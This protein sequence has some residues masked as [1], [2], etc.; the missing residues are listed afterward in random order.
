MARWVVDDAGSNSQ[1]SEDEQRQA[2]VGDPHDPAPLLGPRELPPEVPAARGYQ[3]RVVR[4]PLGGGDRLGLAAHGRRPRRNGCGGRVRSM[5]LSRVGP[6]ADLGTLQT[7]CR[8]RPRRP[9]ASAWANGGG[10]A[11][12]GHTTHTK[13]ARGS[14]IALRR[15]CRTP[16]APRGAADTSRQTAAPTLS[17]LR[18]C[19]AKPTP[20]RNAKV[21]HDLDST[22]R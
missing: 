18:S 4:P 9:G 5:D 2:D 19:N 15:R 22:S 10:Q 20:K 13:T 11:V 12:P 17:A 14:R 21:A 6:G 7:T 1:Q 3:R 8:R 16:P